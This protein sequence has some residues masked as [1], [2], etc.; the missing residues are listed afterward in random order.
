M[1]HRLQ[2]GI[3]F[4]R[5]ARPK[6]CYRLLLLDVPPHATSAKVAAAIDRTLRMLNELG[7]GQP[8]ELQGQP[9]EHAA[10]SKQQ[11]RGLDYLIAYGRRFFD[12]D[13]HDPPLTTAERPTY[14]AYLQRERA[15]FPALP[16]A[17]A[18]YDGEA[19]I[20]LQFTA[21][22]DAAVNCAAV[23]VW[24]L[25]TDEALPLQTRAIFDGFGR[26]DGR[27]W[28]D[29]HDGV[30][31][32]ES[33][34]RLEAIEALADPPWMEGGTYMACLR[35]AIDLEAWRALSRAQQELS[36]GRDKLSG[37]ALIAV[38]DDE[39]GNPT[40]IAAAPLGETPTPDEQADWRDPPQTIDP[41]LEAAHI[42]RANQSRASPAAPGALRIFRQGYDFLDEIGAD[43]PRL[44][45]HFVSFQRDLR[46][47]Q[48][49]LHLTSWLGDSNFGG[50]SPDSTHDDATTRPF[51]SLVSGGFYAVP[52][53]EKPFPGAT[54][55]HSTE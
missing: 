3:H 16:W 22:N 32:I 45:L 38:H 49:L 39:Q 35:L 36:V 19:D 44:G 29:F 17:A 52:P 31:N 34:Q 42:H 1:T 37:A 13:I 8:R 12:A 28:L 21:D 53:R 26:R 9:A 23:E 55:F 47:V 10:A 15:P 43:G 18:P 48:Q 14:L 40:P 33:G 5:N 2:R 11:F 4:E 6:P 7:K 41:L 54:L 51:V 20:A 27:G 50:R 25:I 24:K 30:S 46:I